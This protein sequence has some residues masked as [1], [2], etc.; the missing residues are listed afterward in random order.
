MEGIIA[1]AGP[2]AGGKTTAVRHW[3]QQGFSRLNRDEMGGSLDLNGI[4]YTT[5]R[6]QAAQ[7][8]RQFV[9]DNLYATR[10]ARATLLEV[11]KEVGLPVHL[12]WLQTT[13][14]QAQFFACLRQVRRYGRL[15]NESDYRTCNRDDPGAFPP[16]AQFRYWNTREEPS[17]D[18]GFATIRRVDVVIDLGPEYK[19]RAILLDYDGTLRLT[20]S[21]RIY[22]SD[23]SDVVL[24]EGRKEILHRKVKE[25]YLLLGASNQSG[26]AK[27]PGDPKYVSEADAIRCFEE[28]NRL[29]GLTIPYLFAADAAGVPKTFWR[30]PMPGMGVLYIERYKL[31]PKQCIYV[32]DRGED[33][34]FAE[35]CGFQFAWAEEFFR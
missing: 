10:K 24:M 17:E 27:K 5:M 20:R 4:V 1:V 32:G 21:G 8:C 2:P 16:G 22:P 15:L 25:G 19:N 30:K 34:T 3:V 18:E 14:A 28:T 7:G 26:I 35:R 12:E 31:D 11:A 29:L 9:L 33:R 6:Q 23:P 13:A